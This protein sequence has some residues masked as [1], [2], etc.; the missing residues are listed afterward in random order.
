MASP[1][2][3]DELD[4][5]VDLM[6]ELFWINCND[7]EVEG[8]WVC[9]NGGQYDINLYRLSSDKSTGTLENCA[10]MAT[11]GFWRDL[12]CHER[13][14]Y[15]VCKAEQVRTELKTWRLLVSC[16]RGFAR[17]EFP[18]DGL[19]ECAARC[20]RDR[21]ACRS[22]TCCTRRSTASPPEQTAPPRPASSTTPPAPRSTV[23]T[24]SRPTPCA[25][26]ERSNRPRGLATK[27]RATFTS[28]LRGETSAMLPV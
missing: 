26:T 2:T 15:A 8:Q 10:G 25:S 27:Q 22:L 18:V 6:G 16:L 14:R 17:Q 7:M 1:D 19:L 20:G 5:M 23:P 12:R 9:A 21:P 28:K 3:K 13:F 11:D 4:F 24:S